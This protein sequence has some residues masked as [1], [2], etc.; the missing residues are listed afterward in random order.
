MQL[1]LT[2]EET[3]V[4]LNLLTETVEA[5]Y[6]LSPRIQTLQRLLAKFGPI[7]P[8]PPAAGATPTPEEHDPERSPD[9]LERRARQ[10][11]CTTVTIW[12]L[13]LSNKLVR[14]E[15]LEGMP[16]LSGSSS[17]GNPFTVRFQ[18]VGDAAD[19]LGQIY[20]YVGYL[21]PVWPNGVQ[22]R[23]ALVGSVVRTVPHNGG[24]APAGIVASWIALKRS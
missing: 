2:D 22:Q 17:F 20:D 24:T 21:I 9:D 23:P 10:Y 7:G 3:V 18:G 15:E 11:V 13:R 6:P 4:L 16:G 12:S 5:W 14:E 1:D 8:A 19:S